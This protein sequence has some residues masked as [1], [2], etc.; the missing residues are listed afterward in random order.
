MKK[1]KEQLITDNPEL[2]PV[3]INSALVSAQNRRR[4]YWT[5]ITGVTQPEDKNINWGD[6][7]EH[8]V[9]CGPM[10][11]SDKAMDWLG[12][13]GTE[14]GKKLKVHADDKKMQMLEASHYKKY[15][16]QRFFG[17]VDKPVKNGDE[18]DNVISQLPESR[19]P[20]VYRTLEPGEYYRYITPLE[21]ERLQTVPDDY[22]NVAGISNTQRYKMLGNGWTVDVIAHILSC[23][24]L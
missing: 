20:D 9:E 6:V 19:Y 21:C 18:G 8:G 24:E 1:K 11:Y 14:K 3:E 7:R 2:K 10:Y 12:K 13:H 16:S 22:T 17:I 4:L 15:S 23:M 5:N